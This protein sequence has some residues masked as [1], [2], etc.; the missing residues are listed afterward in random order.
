MHCVSEHS[1]IYIYIYI[2]ICIYIYIYICL[3]TALGCID[4]VN[5]D[6]EDLRKHTAMVAGAMTAFGW[7]CIHIAYYIYNAFSIL[8]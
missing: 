8:H 2:C 3:Y 1:M 5:E 4:Q 7:V 6:A